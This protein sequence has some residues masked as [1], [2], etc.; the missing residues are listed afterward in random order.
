MTYPATYS[1]LILTYRRNHTNPAI[2]TEPQWDS[3]E[4]KELF[5]RTCANCHS[6]TTNW[7]WYSN[8]AV[9]SGSFLTIWRRD[10]SILMYLHGDFKN[11]TK[12]KKQLKR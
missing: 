1:D 5:G 9:Q 6:H 2:L 3:S 7:P 11:T 4:T 12:A 10:V 8:V